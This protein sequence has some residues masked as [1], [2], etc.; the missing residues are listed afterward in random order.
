MQL[1]KV[2][3]SGDADDVMAL[4]DLLTG[5][6]GELCAVGEVSAPYP[7]RRDSGVRRYLDVVLTAL[8]DG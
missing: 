4:A 3:L 1:V 6:P 8:A 7:N 5:L 2:R